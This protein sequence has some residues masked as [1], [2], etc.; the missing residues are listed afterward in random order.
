MGSSIIYRSV[1]IYR[2]V[3]N[4]LYRGRYRERFA[5]V[6]ELIRETDRSVLELCFGDVVVA[7]YCRRHGVSWTGL[8]LSEAFVAYAAHQRFDARLA[9]VMQPG[10]L[11][12]CDVCIMMGSLYHF[13]AQ[14]PD[15][16][17]RL[18]A[19]A[20]RLLLSE[21]VRN[22]THAS[23]GLRFLARKLTRAET[24]EETFRF[25]ETSLLRA[26][27][28]LKAEVGFDYRVVSVARDMVVEVVWSN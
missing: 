1:G 12:A 16:F 26:L 24:Q 23:G 14:L 25:D 6:C 20:P 13:N 7:G 22:W 10:A 5:S 28:E 3:M 9:N 17:R 4:V 18:K 8:D 19:A 11:P 15:L 27:G 21:P 2:L